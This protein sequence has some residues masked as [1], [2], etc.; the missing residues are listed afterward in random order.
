VLTVSSINLD[1]FNTLVFAGGGNR[2]W[3]QA[4]LLTR[5]T[6]QG[7]ELPKQLIG[8]SAGA[9]IAAAY[10]AKTIPNALN[11]CV[12]LYRSNPSIV[13]WKKL[14]RL[15]LE[16]AHQKIYPAWIQSFITQSSFETTQASD[17]RLLVAV[18]HPIPVL[19]PAISISLGTAAYLIDKKLWH[20]I[21]PAIPKYVGLRQGFYGLHA[22]ATL[23][24]SHA[25]LCAAAA[26]PPL[27]SAIKIQGRSTFDGGY[28]D[29]APIVVQSA[30]EKT[31]TLVLLT[32]HYPKRPS[33]FQFGGRT[34]LQPSRPVPV[35]TWDCTAKAT[36]IDAFTLGY[37]DAAKLIKI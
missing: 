34:Y 19:G 1:R 35:S 6:E 37:K 7:L 30:L 2:C 27:M 4:G 8:T 3:W 13:R 11:A 5:W 16:F 28:T 23:V 24:E 33:I 21:H 15:R 20:S 25:L 12:S 36:V 17:H 32:R 26:A 9:A 10:V 18:T 31:A 29:N 14:R 22:C